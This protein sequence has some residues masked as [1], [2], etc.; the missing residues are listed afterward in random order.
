MYFSHVATN[1]ER[2]EG[3]HYVSDIVAGTLIGHTIAAAE[4]TF[5]V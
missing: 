3:H 1:F 4:A 2:A 5:L